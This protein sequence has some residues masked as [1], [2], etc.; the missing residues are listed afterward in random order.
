MLAVYTTS[1]AG[2]VGVSTVYGPWILVPSLGVAAALAYQFSLLRDHRWYLVAISCAGIVAA[3]V[4]EWVGL[5][6]SYAYANGSVTLHPIAVE[7]PPGPAHAM[8]VAASLIIL[9][10]PSIRVSRIADVADTA[11]AKLAVQTW[12]LR[13]LV[14]FDDEKSIK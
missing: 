12:Q 2:M 14:A 9:I 11:R 5:L 7:L 4:L 10:F 13:G 8:L 6:S 3:N 1:I